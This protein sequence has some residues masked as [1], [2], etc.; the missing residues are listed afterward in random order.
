ML[1]NTRSSHLIVMLERRTGIRA[2]GFLSLS[3]A[4]AVGIIID[5]LI[6]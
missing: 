1:A 3:I 4:H 6:R 2:L 5:L